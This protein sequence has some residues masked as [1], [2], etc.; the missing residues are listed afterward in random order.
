MNL[1]EYLES[2]ISVFNEKEVPINI[3][4]NE[5]QN[6][7]SVIYGNSK[8][9]VTVKVAPYIHKE[10]TDLLNKIKNPEILKG[11]VIVIDEVKLPDFLN[12]VFKQLQIQFPNI[13]GGTESQIK[14][15]IDSI[16]LSKYGHLIVDDGIEM[17]VNADGSIGLTPQR[18]SM[19]IQINQQLNKKSMGQ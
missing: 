15:N 8:Y 11:N 17:Q 6:N 4:T 3:Q 10:F 19:N 2:K 7:V 12:D 1:W 18:K 14:P 5:A 13:F 9:T 16:E